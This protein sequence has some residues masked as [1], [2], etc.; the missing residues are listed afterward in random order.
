MLRHLPL[1]LREAWTF[2]ISPTDPADELVA[3]ALLS[4]AHAFALRRTV[5]PA[6]ILLPRLAEARS[7]AELQQV[8]GQ[9]T[10]QRRPAC[11]SPLG[12]HSSTEQAA[13]AHASLA[14]TASDRIPAAGGEPPHLRPVLLA[15]VPLLRR[16]C[17]PR[18]GGGAALQAGSPH[19]QEHSRHGS[20]QA[21]AGGH[22]KGVCEAAPEV[23]QT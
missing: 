10:L 19:R 5:T 1:S 6:A 18:G 8:R 22:W 13:C 4:L 9:A 20:S 11:A 16:L 2:A 12:L 23:R 14:C 15:G 3:A 21:S 17:R 7:E